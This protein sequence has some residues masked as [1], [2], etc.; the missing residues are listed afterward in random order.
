MDKIYPLQMFV[1]TIAKLEYSLPAALMQEQ[2]TYLNCL[3]LCLTGNEGG[4]LRGNEDVQH[5]QTR[6]CRGRMFNIPK[7]GSTS[8]LV[9]SNNPGGRTSSSLW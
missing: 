6:K 4:C 3:F 1:F 8:V 9:A 5:P 2:G 7:Q